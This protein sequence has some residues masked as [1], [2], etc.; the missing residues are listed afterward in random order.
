MNR[1]ICGGVGGGGSVCCG[2]VVGMIA[3]MVVE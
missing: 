1:G 3:V 2:V